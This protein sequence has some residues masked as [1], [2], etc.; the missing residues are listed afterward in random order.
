MSAAVELIHQSVLRERHPVPAVQEPGCLSG[1]LCQYGV[2]RRRGLQQQR[3]F[4]LAAHECE[5]PKPRQ[6]FLSSEHVSVPD[7]P[8]LPTNNHSLVTCLLYY[9]PLHRSGALSDAARLT[10]DVCPS[11][12]HIGSKSRTERPRKTK[13]GTEAAHV[14]RDSDTA[15]K[16]KRWK[17]NLQGRGHIVAASRTALF[18]LLS[19]Y[20]LM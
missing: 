12:A 14:T 4:L 13:I 17:V 3:Q 15:F 8:D 19:I 18:T 16:V 2:M 20:T 7:W 5:Q 11:V 1:I 9:D 6:H 10:S